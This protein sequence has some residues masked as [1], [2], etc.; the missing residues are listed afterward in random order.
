[1]NHSR[2]EAT[3]NNA[4]NALIIP[5]T[6][7]LRQQTRQIR[8]GTKSSRRRWTEK[9]GRKNLDIEHIAQHRDMNHNFSAYFPLRGARLDPRAV[10]EKLPSMENLRKGNLSDLVSD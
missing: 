7:D 1:M 6:V 10:H 2:V 4:G 5:A 3:F 8:L 9:Q